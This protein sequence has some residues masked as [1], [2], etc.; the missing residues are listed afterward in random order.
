M[1]FTIVGGTT[2]YPA[3]TPYQKLTLTE[4]IVV[5]WPTSFV[6]GPVIFGFNDVVSSDGV[7]TIT[8]P[9]ATLGAQGVDILFR[10]ASSNNFTIVDNA[11]STIVTVTP[12]LTINLKLTDNTIVE[13]EW[14]VLP[15]V[16]GYSGV[17]SF[18][19]E[20]SDDSIVITNGSIGSSGGTI[21][22][23]LPDSINNLNQLNAVGLATIAQTNPIIWNTVTLANGSNISIGNPDGTTGNP[24][25]SLSPSITGI[26][27]LD[28]GSMNIAGNE[29]ASIVSGQGIRLKSLNASIII[30][31]VIVEEDS[32]I[33]NS[34]ITTDQIKTNDL[35]VTNKLT[36]PYVPAAWVRFI[37][38]GTGGLAIISSVNVSSIT[39]SST[40]AYRIVFQQDLPNTAYATFVTPGTNITTLPTVIPNLYHAM[41]TLT[42]QEAVEII[43]LDAS[44]QPTQAINGINVSV[45]ST[46]L[47]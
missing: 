4:D 35:T 3:N 16:G 7:Y 42:D 13:G 33:T 9:D 14:S 21:D 26:T 15:F 38:N 40:G 36:N 10:N 30:N 20:S 1:T 18:T 12:G 22:F 2:T 19:A 24:T 28:I 25:I 11:S 39:S 27:S 8:L 23:V 34:K 47:P 43:L 45:M 44:G 5:S 41:V 37:D 29:I 31:D 17:P 6:S 46:L 32:A